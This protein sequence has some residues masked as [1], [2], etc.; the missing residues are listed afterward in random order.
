M[1]RV[2]LVDDHPV[3][4]EG[5]AA[6]LAA[7]PDVEIVGFGADGREAIESARKLEPDV[8]VIDVRLPDVEGI[9]VCALLLKERPELRV[10]M[11]TRFA[12]ERVM[13]KAFEAGAHAYL[14]KESEPLLF[15]Q[16]L[17]IV[18]NG[19]TFV[20]PRLADRLVLSATRG[21]R[22]SRGPLGLTAQELRVIGLL[23]NGFS[24]RQ[25]AGELGI[26]IDTVK[27]HLRNAMRKLGAGDRAA[28]AAI[29][30]EKGLV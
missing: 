24:N 27:T 23:P 3:V 28:V 16:A 21:R 2:L 17:R 26:S 7:D 30:V 25:I 13:A 12:H 20:D 4:R 6:V 10:M 1:T 9:D 19:G 11:V 15:R 14:V 29:A 8:L 22:R 5:I 18:A